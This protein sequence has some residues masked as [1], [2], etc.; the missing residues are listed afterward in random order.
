MIEMNL[1]HFSACSYPLCTAPFTKSTIFIHYVFS[2]FVKN[3]VCM[4]ADLCLGRK[5]Y[6]NGQFFLL[7]SLW[8]NLKSEPVIHREVIFIIVDYL[9]IVRVCMWVYI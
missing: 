6:Y 8:Y 7:V 1:F 2:V 3:H 9:I 4:C 5:S